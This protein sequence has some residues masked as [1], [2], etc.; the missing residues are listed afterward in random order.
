MDLA[1]SGHALTLVQSR[2]FFDAN[3]DH[4]QSGKKLGV[5]IERKAETLIGFAGLVACNALGQ[6][7]HELGF[8]LRRE[9]WGHGYAAE[10]GLGQLRYGFET[11]RLKRVLAQVDP[12]N[13]TSISVITKIGM[14]F[15]ASVRSRDRGERHVYVKTHM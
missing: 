11:L 14:T 13:A 2:T 10:I 7:D 8:V 4:D 5:L 1:F 12:R 15:H 6:P 9:A 3:F